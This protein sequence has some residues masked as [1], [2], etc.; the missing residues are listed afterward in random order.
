MPVLRKSSCNA[1]PRGTSAQH[2][3][4]LSLRVCGI[5]CAH[6]T[7]PHKATATSRPDSMVHLMPLA[8]L[9]SELA[10]KSLTQAISRARKALRFVA[11]ISRLLHYFP[12]SPPPGGRAVA[13]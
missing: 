1:I 5:I 10:L 13:C 3:K 12:L 11:A 7:V 4:P 6:T 2:N 8:P 9:S